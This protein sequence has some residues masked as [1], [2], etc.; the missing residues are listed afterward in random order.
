MALGS[1][2]GSEFPC[3]E[4]LRQSRE[5]H[6]EDGHAHDDHVVADAMGREKHIT[7]RRRGEAANPTN[8]F[9]VKDARGAHKFKIEKH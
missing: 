7:G 4:Q 2:P 8:A 3:G 5:K 1:A 9:T 6:Q